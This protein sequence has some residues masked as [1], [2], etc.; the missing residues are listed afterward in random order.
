MSDK[1]HHTI[2][3]KDDYYNNKTYL[4]IEIGWSKHKDRE[5]TTP[6]LETNR[7]QAETLAQ[8]LTH[9][10]EH[11]SK[12][13]AFLNSLIDPLLTELDNERERLKQLNAPCG[14]HRER[15]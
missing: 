13:G 10:G 2:I 9:I 7:K 4:Q 12:N 14:A 15:E 5:Y 3:H 1:A 6:R 11:I 8:T